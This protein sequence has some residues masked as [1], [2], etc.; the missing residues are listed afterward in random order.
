MSEPS[1]LPLPLPLTRRH[2]QRLREMHRSAGWP[3]HDAIEVELIAAGCLQRCFDGV[4]REHLRVSDE[5][6]ALL[7]RIYARNRAALSAHEALVQRVALEQARAGRLAWCGL[8]LRAPLPREGAPLA[9]DWVVACP[10]VYSIRRSSRTDWLEPVVHEIKVS[11]ADLLSDLRKA[12]KRAA[13]LGMAGA[14]WYVLGRDAKGRPVGDERDVPEDC[15]V[16]VDAG[17]A[18]GWE[19]RREAPR[20]A[21]PQLPLGVWLA[22]AQATPVRAEEPDQ[23]GL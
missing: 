3:C 10:D 1:P 22:L 7:A 5:G 8:A 9:S 2:H 20:R 23:Q 13:Y 6:I 14:V 11:R 21:V 15:G 18:G 17:T 12:D 16:L 4:G 19:L